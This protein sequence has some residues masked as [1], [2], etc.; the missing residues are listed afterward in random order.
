MTDP[1]N[2]SATPVEPEAPSGGP[3]DGADA[4]AGAGT[5]TSEPVDL[6]A[7]ERDLDDV[8]AALDRLN[9]GTYWTDETT[10]EPIPDVV[11]DANPTARTTGS[12]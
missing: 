4:A 6:D 3:R 7:I 2:P 9:D 1:S 8:Q 11:L 10:G 12:G 5:A